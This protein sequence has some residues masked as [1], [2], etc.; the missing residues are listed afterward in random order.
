MVFVLQVSANNVKGKR[1][2]NKIQCIFDATVDQAS[3]RASGVTLGVVGGTYDSCK[4]ILCKI[5]YNMCAP[6]HTQS[7][8]EINHLFSFHFQLPILLEQQTP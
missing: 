4:S 6:S 8:L 7:N 5:F 2:G 3:G 1:S